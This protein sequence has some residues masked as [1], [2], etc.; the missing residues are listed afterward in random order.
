[1]K[2]EQ[3]LS[4]YTKK[5]WGI[6]DAIALVLLIEG[7]FMFLSSIIWVFTSDNTDKWF[8]RIS[9]GLICYGF[10][11]IIFRLRK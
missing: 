11:G 2:E 3:N 9:M 1:M 5:V 7:T 6:A 4:E 8:T 10:A